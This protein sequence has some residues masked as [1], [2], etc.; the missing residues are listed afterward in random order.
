VSTLG[1]YNYGA[2]F[3]STLTGR[4]L[5]P[6]PVVQ[7]VKDPQALNAYSYVRNNPL[8]Y[9][10]PT[11]LYGTEIVPQS[12]FSS[13]G[14]AAG[15][16]IAA[17]LLQT[18]DCA[19]NGNCAGVTQEA[20]QAQVGAS[21]FWDKVTSLRGFVGA[22][23]R[24]DIIALIFA[25][26][27]TDARLDLI[28][29]YG[30]NALASMYTAPQYA[31]VQPGAITGRFLRASIYDI[32][33]GTARIMFLGERD[34]VGAYPWWEV[35]SWKAYVTINNQLGG[36]AYRLWDERQWLVLKTLLVAGSLMYSDSQCKDLNQMPWSMFQRD[37]VLS[38]FGL[39]DT[40][41]RAVRAGAVTPLQF[42][43]LCAAYYP[44]CTF[45]GDYRR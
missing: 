45:I 10:D 41:E 26:E 16:G 42:R 13:L 20:A 14:G 40:Y 18:L 30:W 25:A 33:N 24:D 9:V 44:A 34:M 32:A 7:D 12:P 39:V 15:A 31:R 4:F 37:E 6:D 43:N 2:R 22:D 29:V 21:T 27:V 17:D 36:L 1:L 23:L 5:S 28:P 11:G 19:L 38:R 8:V 3:Y 35:L